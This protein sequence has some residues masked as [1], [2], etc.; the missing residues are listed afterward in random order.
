[1]D[2]QHSLQESDSKCRLL[3]DYPSLPYG[4]DISDLPAEVVQKHTSSNLVRILLLEEQNR[5]LHGRA[6]PPSDQL[7]DRPTDTPVKLWQPNL[8][9]MATYEKRNYTRSNLCSSSQP[10]MT[11]KTDLQPSG[12]QKYKGH[13][14]H[15]AEALRSASQLSQDHSESGLANHSARS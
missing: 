12:G 3:V 15:L 1:M 13:M 7:G 8:F 10:S 5:D 9:K 2:L 14:G 6:A 4:S 11:T